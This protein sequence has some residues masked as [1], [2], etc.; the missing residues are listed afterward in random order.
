MNKMSL[1]AKLITL[2][3]SFIFFSIIIGVIG[4]LATTRV[5]NT[6]ATI[7][8]QIIPMLKNISQLN[9]TLNQARI[10]ILTLSRGGETDK[11]IIDIYIKKI[12]ENL[13]LFNES[14]KVI[15][16][17]AGENEKKIISDINKITKKLENDF[18]KSIELLKKSN[19][20]NSIE[21]ISMNKII[22]EDLVI[23]ANDLEEAL[24]NL[25]KFEDEKS[26][27]TLA[28]ANT[29][30]KNGASLV[31]IMN[32]I[33]LA[34]GGIFTFYITSKLLKSFRGI[35]LA[36]NTSSQ[37]VAKVASDIAI[38]S[39]ELS[40]SSIQQSS[41]LIE[42]SSSVEETS[43]MA[44]NNTE[45]AISAASLSKQSEKSALHG[46]EVVGQMIQTINEINISNS[47][48]MT[49]V[50][51]SNKQFQEIVYVIQ[52]IGSKTK[53]INDIVFQTKLLSFNASVE[54]AR[55]G[56]HGK[57]FAVVAEEIGKLA[58]MSGIASSDISKML[59]ES[60]KNVESIVLETK[61]SVEKLIQEGRNKVN[62]GIK[63][64]NEC[65]VVL[66]DIVSNISKV[67]LM[68]NEIATASDE[69]SHQVLE[70]S[71]VV[72]QLS[73]STQQNTTSANSSSQL[74][75]DLSKQSDTMNL[76]VRELLQTIEGT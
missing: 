21:M 69:Q 46:Q 52:S 53:V 50:N 32:I 41:A 76:L 61:N 67:A 51:E 3:S 25:A 6:Y 17:N 73:R 9:N 56:E 48:I 34:A 37:E 8:T 13:A 57:G 26:N 4:N 5:V 47:N 12:G 58:Q 62:L 74:A 54:A 68:S 45:G 10:N 2:A 39:D 72:N 7:N 63:V 44:K 27:N 70:I 31:I 36:L 16:M 43:A 59:E 18:S 66:N 14:L 19:I 29:S 28:E 1:K 11:E 23:D 24:K 65:G 75:E 40:Q 71:N 60:I 33:S 64:A 42:T 15:S 30:K 35:G 55:A 49:Q 20:K 38:A 22:D